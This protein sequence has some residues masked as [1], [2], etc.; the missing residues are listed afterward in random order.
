MDNQ[1]QSAPTPPAPL[2]LDLGCGC[3]KKDG[4]VGV[5]IRQF[6]GVDIV[7]DL[8]TPWPWPDN[9]VEE[10]HCAH[11]VEHLHHSEEQP[12]RVFFCNEL[13]RVLVPGGKALIV[14]PCWSSARAY[15]DYQHK[16][17]PVSPWWFYYLTKRWRVGDPASGVVPNA[18]HNDISYDPAGYS[19][20]F[21]VNFGFSMHPQIALRNQEM[22][23]FALT[24]YIEA[25]QDI[26]ATFQKPHA[27]R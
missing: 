18:P 20:D 6:P 25:G 16:W 5:D 22:Q 23:Q 15:G 11:F 17:P 10:V 8:R 19:C 13:Y 27:L 9:S 4:F 12:E 21:D 7:H 14:V 2:R 26:V 24:F 1:D 3:N